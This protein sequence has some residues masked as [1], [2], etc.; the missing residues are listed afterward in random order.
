MFGASGMKIELSLMELNHVW[1]SLEH[2][3][4][5]HGEVMQSLKSQVEAAMAVP[6]SPV[7]PDQPND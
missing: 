7:E 2:C 4:T 6:A 5:F 1:K 3:N